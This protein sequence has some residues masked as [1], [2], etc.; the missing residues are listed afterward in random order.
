MRVHAPTWPTSP[1]FGD[2]AAVRPAHGRARLFSPTGSTR[3]K[4]SSI[5]FPDL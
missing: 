5:R 4:C 1:L 3:T 2:E